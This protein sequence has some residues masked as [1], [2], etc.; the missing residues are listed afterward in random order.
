MLALSRMASAIGK[1]PNAC[2]LDD[3]ATAQPPDEQDVLV[4][5]VFVVSVLDFLQLTPQLLFLYYL[6]LVFF[7]L[8]PFCGVCIDGRESRHCNVLLADLC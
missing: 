6:L 8:S 7:R 3:I 1:M 2:Q 4:L 5:Q